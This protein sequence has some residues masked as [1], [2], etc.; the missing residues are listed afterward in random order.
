MEGG[1]YL[2]ST[3]VIAANFEAHSGN[4]WVVPFGGGI[5]RI[6][7]VGHQPINANV[8]AYYNVEDTSTSGDWSIVT[9]WSFLFPK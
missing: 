3:P 4:R 5:G 8:K 9:Q 7:K 6:F 1:W 2:S